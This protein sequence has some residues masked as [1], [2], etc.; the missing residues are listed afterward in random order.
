MMLI[1]A[2]LPKKFTSMQFAIELNV[3][4]LKVQ[5]QQEPMVKFTFLLFFCAVWQLLYFSFLSS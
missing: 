4:T 3:A 1:T 2:Y 5:I